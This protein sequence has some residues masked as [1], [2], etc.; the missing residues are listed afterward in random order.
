MRPGW[1]SPDALRTFNPRIWNAHKVQAMAALP[2]D[3]G[4]LRGLIYLHHFGPYVW[5]AAQLA[6]VNRFIQRHAIRALRRMF[7]KIEERQRSRQVAALTKLT[8]FR[9]RVGQQQPTLDELARSARSTLAADAV[10]VM[11]QTGNQRAYGFTAGSM[12]DA[13]L[14]VAE[15]EAWLAAS[16]RNDAFQSDARSMSAAVRAA[17]DASSSRQG[18]VSAAVIALRDSAQ[19][20]LGLIYIGFRAYRAFRGA[21]KNLIRTI[22]Q[23]MSGVIEGSPENEDE[24]E[25]LVRTV[26]RVAT[27]V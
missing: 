14:Q 8:L 27:S 11:V 26:S 17:A 24:L 4:E 16:G 6:D 7:D 2:L 5:D 25:M 3:D 19:N 20:D 10:T 18:Y 9:A 21:E 15:G 1:D 12:A 22:A 23:L 13:Q